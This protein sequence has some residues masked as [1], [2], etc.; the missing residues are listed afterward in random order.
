M[1]IKPSLDQC[2]LATAVSV[3][4]PFDSERSERPWQ[5]HCTRSKLLHLGAGL[6]VPEW[7]CRLFVTV[8]FLLKI[9]YIPPNIFAFKMSSRSAM[10]RKSKP[11]E[12]FQW[13]NIWINIAV[14]RSWDWQSSEQEE[15]R[16]YLSLRL[17]VL[18]LTSLMQFNLISFESIFNRLYGIKCSVCNQ[19]VKRELIMRVL[20]N[21]YHLRCFLCSLCGHPLQRGDQ[22]IIRHGQLICSMDF[23]RDPMSLHQCMAFKASMS[24]DKVIGKTLSTCLHWTSWFSSFFCRWWKHDNDFACPNS[25]WHCTTGAEA[26]ENHSY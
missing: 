9:I 7:T 5:C 4:S 21:I 8:E 22:F 24:I 17:L 10:I 2:F 11:T 12:G 15:R 1:N 14:S 3:W 18:A 25:S 16:K 26:A 23:D 20:G 19:L 6:C 13:N